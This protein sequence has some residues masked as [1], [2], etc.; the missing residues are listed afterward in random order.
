VLS[1]ENRKENKAIDN[2]KYSEFEGFGKDNKVINFREKVSSYE[3]RGDS[4]TMPSV[5]LAKRT[6]DIV[7][8]LLVTKLGISLRENDYNFIIN[9]MVI[10]SENMFNIKQFFT[11]IY[12]SGDIINKDIYNFKDQYVKKNLKRY[13]LNNMV[14]M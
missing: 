5:I 12:K 14:H 2:I 1:L 7:L 13:Q 6:S 8:N 11:I 10:N 3:E 4:F 9:Q